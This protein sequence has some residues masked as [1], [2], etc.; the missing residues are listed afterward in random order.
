MSKCYSIGP[1]WHDGSVVVDLVVRMSS[2]S[3]GIDDRLGWKKSIEKCIIMENRSF[4]NGNRIAFTESSNKVRQLDIWDVNLSGSSFKWT[5][6]NFN[7]A[8]FANV[9]RVP[10][11]R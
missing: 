3:P 2:C 6:L 7:R 9:R 1:K 10:S 8:D 4:M 11:L 5:H